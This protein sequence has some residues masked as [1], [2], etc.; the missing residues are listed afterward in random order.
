M[1]I[2]SFEFGSIRIDGH[3]Y[4]YDVVLR[5]GEIRRRKKKASK[6][7]KGMFG[8]TPLSLAED[9]PWKCDRLV[10][11]T[12]A[13]GRLPVMHEVSEEAERR[14]V[15]LL[16]LPTREAIEEV[17]RGDRDEKRTNAVLHVTC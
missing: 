2:E 7:Y 5:K 17:N 3:T 9:I 1:H 15:E 13:Y 11:G 12:G 4:D 6:P 10:I 8:H 16:V 14:G